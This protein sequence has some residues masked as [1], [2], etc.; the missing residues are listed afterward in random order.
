MQA[1]ALASAFVISARSRSLRW[2]H[3]QRPEFRSG[4][5]GFARRRP[6]GNHPDTLHENR[7]SIR[8]ALEALDCD[9]R[10]DYLCEGLQTNTGEA[11]LLDWCLLGPC[12]AQPVPRIAAVL[13]AGQRGVPVPSLPQAQSV[14]RSMP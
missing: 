14:H 8:P 1:T 9:A 13:P 6:Q 11:S 3:E 7:G 12:G 2:Q 5:I 10:V 4:A